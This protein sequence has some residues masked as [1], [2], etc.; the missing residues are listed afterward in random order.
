MSNI[1]IESWGISSQILI[2]AAKNMWFSAHIFSQENNLFSIYNNVNKKVY[3]KS[4]DGWLNSSFGLKVAD[5]KELTYTLAEDNNIRVPKNIYLNKNQLNS[6]YISR[7][8]IEYPVI[9]KPVDWARGEWVSLNLKNNT[10]LLK[11]LKYSFDDETV[12]R[13]VIQE[14][15]SWDDHRI[16]VVDWKVEAVTKRIPPFVVWNGTNNIKE[17][18]EIENTNPLRW[19]WWDHDAPMSKIKIDSESVEFIEALWY[20][21]ES[22]LEADKKVKVRKNANLSTWWLAIDVTDYIHPSIS[23]QAVKLSQ[24]CWLGLC[25]V[26]FFCRDISQELITWKGAI[27]EVNATPGIR[28]HHFPNQGEGRDIATKILLALFN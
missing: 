26:D 3:F 11:W 19:G 24:I 12:T 23:D 27:I 16:L 25:W 5:N 1:L 7:L 9:S 15:L 10:D 18:I 21:L 6:D 17:L 13:V 28:M 8:D 2:D 22:V 4:I 20:K 14:E